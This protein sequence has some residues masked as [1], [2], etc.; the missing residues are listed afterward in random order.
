MLFL[1]K[2]KISFYLF[3]CATLIL[4]LLGCSSHTDIPIETTLTVEPQLKTTTADWNTKY[5]NA[6]KLE[7]DIPIIKSGGVYYLTG[8]I[9]ETLLVDAEEQIVHLILDNVEIESAEGPAIHVASAG[10]VFLTLAEGSVNTLQDSGN[11]S[12]ETDADACIYSI[13]D[14]TINGSGKLYIY[15]YHKDAVHTKD[16]LKVL[17]GSLLVQSKRDGLRGNDGIL[18]SCESVMVQSER[19][20]LRTTKNGR[21]AKGNIEILSGM[22]SVIGGNYAIS[23]AQDLYMKDCSIYLVGVVGPTEVIGNQYLQEGCLIDG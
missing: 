21:P 2:Y 6:Q 19:N 23:C 11:Y 18:I 5:D 16:V 20:G 7:N 1:K 13:C 3:L 22:H 15:G 12:A 14:L 17:G 10:K 4:P 8:S 9:Q